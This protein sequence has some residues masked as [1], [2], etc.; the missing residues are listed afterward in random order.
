MH[1]TTLT[2]QCKFVLLR[3]RCGPLVLERPPDK[4]AQF[5]PLPVLEFFESLRTTGA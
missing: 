5:L 4:T 3:A 2:A 1:R